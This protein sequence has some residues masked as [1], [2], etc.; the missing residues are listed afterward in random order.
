MLQGERGYFLVTLQTCLAL[1]R[2]LDKDQL[3]FRDLVHSLQGPDRPSTKRV[4][5]ATLSSVGSDASE[6]SASDRGSA[7][8]LDRRSSLDEEVVEEDREWEK[9]L[10]RMEETRNT[11]KHM[12]EIDLTSS[13]TFGDEDTPEGGEGG[14]FM[15]WAMTFL[16]R[17]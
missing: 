14:D 15:G 9:A 7:V 10:T 4:I 8:E 13:N 12:A 11:E 3:E 5:H 6:G 16:K 17:N 1:V 2:C